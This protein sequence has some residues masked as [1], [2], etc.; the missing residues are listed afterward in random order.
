MQG[1]E[2]MASREGQLTRMG[3]RKVSTPEQGLWER[4]C[5]PV[6]SHDASL[7]TLFRVVRKT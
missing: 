5:A 2:V 6:G 7:V 1:L 4:Q 3:L